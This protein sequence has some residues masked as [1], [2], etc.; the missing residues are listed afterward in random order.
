VVRD[1]PAKREY[2]KRAIENDA[3]K[4]RKIVIS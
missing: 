1:A 4:E 2:S 3:N